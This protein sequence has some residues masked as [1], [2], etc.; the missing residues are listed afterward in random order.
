MS[1]YSYYLLPTLVIV[2]FLYC[3]ATASN[4]ECE[5][6]CHSTRVYLACTGRQLTTA[7]N[8]RAPILSVTYLK[9]SAMNVTTLPEKLPEI[10]KSVHVLDIQGALRSLNIPRFDHLEELI[11][12]DI[13]STLREINVTSIAQQQD[14]NIVDII[15]G[16][17][18]YTCYSNDEQNFSGRVANLIKPYCK[19]VFVSVR[20][21]SLSVSFVQS[22]EI[23]LMYHTQTLPTT[24][25]ESYYVSE[26]EAIHP[27]SSEI[28]FMYDTRILPTPSAES[29]YVSEMEAIH[30]ESSEIHF[31]YDTRI[32]P[33]PSAESYYVSEMEAI[34]PES[35]EIHFM[36]DTRIL[37]TPSAESYYVSEMEA[38]H[39]ESSEIHFMYDTPILPMPS[40]ENT[41]VSSVVKPS[42]MSTVYPTQVSKPSDE[43]DDTRET[44]LIVGSVAVAVFI[45]LFYCCLPWFRC[46][47][48]CRKTLHEEPQL[49]EPGLPHIPLTV[50]SVVNTEDNPHIIMETYV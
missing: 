49:D 24:S 19:T 44:I 34:H 42:S 35:S 27:E 5:T 30:P 16:K 12:E 47:C 29:Y 38:I 10:F 33:T 14:L 39:P 25:A 20:S 31:M 28:H 17:A 23:N 22:S 21:N 50:Y 3:A 36:Y 46:R 6:P 40:A 9:L 41:P 13:F 48:W 1:C 4:G 7:L 18:N 32:L 15:E 8:C 11:V 43:K 2:C 45:T 26:M 37:P